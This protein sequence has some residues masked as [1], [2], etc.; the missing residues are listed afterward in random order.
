M[1]GAKSSIDGR[2]GLLQA[3]L[4][5]LKIFIDIAGSDLQNMT[6]L[7]LFGGVTYR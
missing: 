3:I 1:Q 4:L 2:L 7:L 6:T 5:F